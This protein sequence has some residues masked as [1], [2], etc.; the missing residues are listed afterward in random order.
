[1]NANEK[2]KNK[3]G[4]PRKVAILH[5]GNEAG[6]RFAAGLKFAIAGG[7]EPAKKAC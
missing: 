2:P 3:G 4:R 5:R 7:S 6:K 1:V